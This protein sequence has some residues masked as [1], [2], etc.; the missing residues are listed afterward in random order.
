[1]H[2]KAK[3]KKA[4]LLRALKA[5]PSCKKKS[6]QGDDSCASGID[7]QAYV[8]FCSHAISKYN[9]VPLYII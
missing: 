2:A 9:V 3:E 4:A 5:K 7:S 6:R 8:S 1:M